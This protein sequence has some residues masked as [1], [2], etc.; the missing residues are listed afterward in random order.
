MQYVSLK[1]ELSG[2]ESK[3][4]I[5]TPLRISIGFIN[6]LSGIDLSIGIH[7]FTT[8]GDCIFDVPSSSQV[9]DVGKY[10]CSC[11]IPGNFLNDG[12]YYIS[13]IF[14]KNTEVQMFYLEKC[15]SFEMEDYRGDIKWQGKWMGWVR[16]R[17]QIEISKKSDSVHA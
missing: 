7:L 8:A 10:E 12:D 2:T 13:V 1:P 9:L 5:R 14:M 3:I 4:D 15:L 16:P 17:F 6:F 11:I